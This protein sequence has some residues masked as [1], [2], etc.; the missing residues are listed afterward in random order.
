[1]ALIGLNVPISTTIQTADT[2]VL[3]VT[4]EDDTEAGPAELHPYDTHYPMGTALFLD[5]LWLNNQSKC[6]DGLQSAV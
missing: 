6:S 5:G 2:G 3:R 1:M 4:G